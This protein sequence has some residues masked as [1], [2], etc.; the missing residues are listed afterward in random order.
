[1][2][3]REEIAARQKQ[4]VDRCMELTQKASKLYNMDIPNIRVSFNLTG[5]TAGYAHRKFGAYSV[6]FNFEMIS[7]EDP[8]AF[9]DMLN[10][11]V[12]HELAHIVCFINSALGKNHDYGWRRVCIALGGT[13]KTTHDLEV[14]YA[15][16]TFTYI[17]T[18]GVQ[19]DVSKVLHARIQGGKEYRFRNGGGTLNRFCKF[20]KKGTDDEF[21]ATTTQHSLGTTVS[22][23]NL[24]YVKK[25]PDVK[26]QVAVMPAGMSKAAVSRGIMERM[27][28]QG[29]SYEAIITAMQQA[30]GY[31]RQLARGTYKANCRKVGIPESF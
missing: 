9:N 2:I 26:P 30:C 10:D 21:K 5:A 27:Y 16:E 3:N 24:M 13:G 31:D 8:A 1:M 28:K 7:R 19:Q 22:G 12:P 17:S 18:T 11:T 25:V 29:A 6:R 15:G 14:N 20:K 23:Q 4:I